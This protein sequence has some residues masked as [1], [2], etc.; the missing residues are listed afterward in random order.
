MANPHLTPLLEAVERLESAWADA[1][2]AAEF[3]RAQLLE[4]HS[5]MGLVQRRL[6]GIHAELAASIARESRPELGAA[7]L[8]KE[9]GFRSPATMIAAT[10]GGSTGDAARLVKVGEATAPRANLIGE[11]LPPRYP[12]VQRAIGEGRSARQRRH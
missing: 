8:A 3:S 7:S 6:D 10:T 1:G 9:Q 2:N 4:A 12:E 5:A 11:A